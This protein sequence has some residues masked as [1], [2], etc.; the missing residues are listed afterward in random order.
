MN[1][2]RFAYRS[3][4]GLRLWLTVAFTVFGLSACDTL[5]TN[6]T[7]TV[8]AKLPT[9]VTTATSAPTATSAVTRTPRAAS[10]WKTYRNER[11]GYT[12]DYPAAWAI[13]ERIDS[14]GADV[15]TF[16][17]DDSGMSVT[18]IVQNVEP[19][20]QE[21]P[22]LPNTRCQQMTVG[23]LSGTQCIDTISFSMT[24]TLMLE[25]KAYI[26]VGSGKRLDQDIYQRFLDG[27]T[28]KS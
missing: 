17:P 8:T 21:T 1:V 7:Q 5:V 9:A 26:L 24:T 22:D 12:I 3:V 4:P 25:G 23:T 14:D 28:I 11:A 15:T 16:S 2:Y 10:D 6:F 27:F 13:N 20:D 19:V 18:V